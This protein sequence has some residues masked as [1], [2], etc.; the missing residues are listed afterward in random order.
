MALNHLQVPQPPRLP[1]H[2]RRYV[3]ELETLSPGQIDYST[4]RAKLERR[5]IRCC[6]IVR[7]IRTNSAYSRVARMK[8]KADDEKYEAHVEQCLVGRLRPDGKKPSKPWS[9]PRYVPLGVCG[10]NGRS[11]QSH[12]PRSLASSSRRKLAS[13][14][15]TSIAAPGPEIWSESRMAGVGKGS[16]A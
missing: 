5:I 8:Q 16:V 1:A 13:L 7:K 15:R 2:L 4:A 9:L 6:E 3:L 14:W 10:G 11:R 12:G